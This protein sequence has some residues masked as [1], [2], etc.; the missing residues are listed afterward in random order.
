VPS[1]TKNRASNYR[2]TLNAKHDYDSRRSS[3][4]SRSSAVPR[5]A[6]ARHTFKSAVLN[7]V[8]LN[9]VNRYEGNDNNNKY[10]YEYGCKEE[11]ARVKSRS[12]AFHAEKGVEEHQKEKKNGKE[13]KKEKCQKK[14]HHDRSGQQQ[15]QPQLSA[16]SGVD[17]RKPQP[18][19]QGPDVTETS[20][21]PGDECATRAPAALSV[22]SNARNYETKKR[23]QDKIC[24]NR[25]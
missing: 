1:R 3:A 7:Q 24:G 6:P 5:S 11:R 2:L 22:A 21:G 10:E 18:V 12:V 17:A 4:T 9:Q 25:L 16:S 23:Q 8:H 13:K 20:V 14:N 19:A 15:Q